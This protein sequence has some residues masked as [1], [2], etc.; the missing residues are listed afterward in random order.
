[1]EDLILYVT[2]DLP[3]DK[4]SHVEK[5]LASGCRRCTG[6]LRLLKKLKLAG[7]L[8]G[9]MPTPEELSRE[10]RA[11]DRPR[12]RRAVGER[13]RTLVAE[14]VYDSR[15]R[16]AP[17]GLRALGAADRQML[18]RFSDYDVDFRFSQLPSSPEFI[19][20]GQLLGSSEGVLEPAAYRCHLRPTRG[21]A[22]TVKLNQ[23]GEFQIDTIKPG[24]YELFLSAP[25]IKIM[26]TT[27]DLEH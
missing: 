4:L 8:P 19:L 21:G 9:L 2:D 25:G 20:S 26:L 7:Q 22:R 12:P 16:P 3:Q 11:L 5:H 27:I 24:R 6:N 23:L 1:L 17:A 10:I 15:L 13:I 18:F 14:L